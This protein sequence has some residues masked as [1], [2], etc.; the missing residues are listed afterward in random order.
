M[1]SII[2]IALSI[3]GF[4]TGISQV[5]VTGTVVGTDGTPLIGVNILEQGTANGAVTD[6]DGTFTLEVPTEA[7]LVFSYTGMNTTSV[8][9]NGRT[10]LSV[11]MEESSTL[12]DEVVVTALGFKEKRD[13]IA[14]TYSKINADDVVQNGESKVIDGIAGKT[15]G[16]R[17]SGASGDPGAGANIQIRGQNTI[18]GDTQPLIIVDGVPLNNDYLRGFGSEIDA[19]VSQQSR[20]NDINPDDIESFQIFKGA[21][22]AALYGTRAMNGAIV[23]TTK[24][25]K[26]GRMNISY[27]GTVGYEE[28]AYK[29]PLQTSFGQ[30]TSGTYNPTTLFSWG[31]K[32]SNRSGGADDV[33]TDGQ[34]FAS[35]VSNNIIYPIN[36][37]NSRDVFPDDNFD[38]VFRNGSSFDNKLSISGGNDRGTFYFSLGRLDQD[39]II[40]N[41]F[42][43]KTNLTAATTQNLTDRLTMN[44]KANFINSKSNRIQQGS[45]TAGLYLGLL[46]T[47]PDF[48]V[49]DYIGDYVSNSGLLPYRGND[50][51]EGI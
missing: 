5:T 32:I 33:D 16:V 27:T 7:T 4:G 40:Q 28:I 24:K 11:T 22:A 37:K 23:I 48:D 34:Y 35:K 39:G 31:D 14:S 21:S 42:F 29:H 50:L 10:N 49:T 3:L 18:S 47:P 38:Q 36:Q 15:S 12:L 13:N 41:S 9:L 30:G 2:F 17:I 8:P 44:V 26:K 20:L 43:D 1:K 45:N 19:G 46:R 25:G 51:T 6:I